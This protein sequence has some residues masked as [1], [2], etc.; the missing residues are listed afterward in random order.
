MGIVSDPPWWVRGGGSF[1]QLYE[2]DQ[3][4]FCSLSSF[5]LW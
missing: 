3:F 5:G 2:D 1:S 4:L